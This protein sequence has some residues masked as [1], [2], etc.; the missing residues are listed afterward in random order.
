MCELLFDEHKAHRLADTILRRW[1]STGVRIGPARGHRKSRTATSWTDA[2]EYTLD[3]SDAALQRK[4]TIMLRAS[5]LAQAIAGGIP[6]L[7]D[8]ADWSLQTS[9]SFPCS[10][11]RE[12][13]IAGIDLLSQRGT[14]SNHSS[15]FAEHQDVWGWLHHHTTPY[16]TFVVKLNRTDVDSRTGVQITGALP[17]FYP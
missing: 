6:H 16:L 3:T 17:W 9:L 13:F 4:E 11:G 14:S 7:A 1:H 10:A 5:V 8:L 12:P 2:F 15:N